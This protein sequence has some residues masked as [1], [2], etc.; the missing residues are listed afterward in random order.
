MPTLPLEPVKPPKDE[1][2][3]LRRMGATALIN[4]ILDGVGNW[5]YGTRS[6]MPT[7]VDYT[8]FLEMLK[9]VGDFIR[10]RPDCAADV[11]QDAL[12]NFGPEQDAQVEIHRLRRIIKEFEENSGIDI[13]ADDYPDRKVARAVKFVMTSKDPDMAI[14]D[15][16]RKVASARQQVS[17]ILDGLKELEDKMFQ[18]R[19]VDA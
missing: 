1:A 5:A 4:A 18:A 7:G 12:R 8:D 19:K 6:H 17:G 13:S 16:E 9:K 15:V 14:L 11:V 10:E 2:E 3:Q